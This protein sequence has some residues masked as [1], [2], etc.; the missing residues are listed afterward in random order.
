M[1]KVYRF[2]AYLDNYTTINAYIKN[3]YYNGKSNKFYLR[4][5][6]GATFEC[7]VKQSE[8]SGEYYKYQIIIDE[9]WV[10]IGDEMDLVEEHGLTCPLQ[11]GLVVR[12]KRFNDE[13]Y[14]DRN[15]F[16]AHVNNNQTSFVLWAPTA[17][18][19]YLKVIEQEKITI[20]PMQKEDKGAWTY[21]IEKNC[22][23]MIYKYIVNVNGRTNEALD[24]YGYGSIENAKASAVI[25]FNQIIT[26]FN[27]D[28]LAPM[29]SYCD[30]II[31][32]LSVRDFSSHP[33]TNI[34]HK[35]QFLG[36]I[37]EGKTD[38]K[39]NPV[40]YDYLK[41]FGYTHIQLMPVFDFATT[42]ELNP[43]M[44]YN[45]G[46]D[47]VQYNALEGSYSKNPKDPLSRINEFIQMIGFYHSKGIRVNMDVVYNHMYDMDDSAFERIVP[48]YYFRQ[49]DQG[50]I[51]NGSFCGNDVDSTNGMVRKFIIDSCVHFV[52]HYHI[53]GLRFDLM[54]ILD[55]ESMNE[56]V[57]K[58]Q[59][60]RADCMIYGEGWNM[61]TMLNEENRAS[62]LNMGEMP[63]VAHFNDFYRN[64]IKGPS[65]ESENH[66]SGYALGDTS[67][68][69]SAK[70]CL[71]GNILDECVVRLFNSP[72]QSLNYVECHD[73]ATLWDKIEKSNPYNTLEQKVNKQKLCNGLIALSFGI[74]FYHIGQEM[75]RTKLGIDN[76]Y[77]SPDE[78]NRVDYNQAKVF[79]EVVRYTKDLIDLRKQLQI[80][81]TDSRDFIQQ[82][83]SFE[84]LKNQAMVMHVDN[85]P[86]YGRISIYVNPS[87]EVIH[88]N[89][90]GTMLANELGK[91]NP[92]KVD[93]ISIKPHSM[94]VI[95]SVI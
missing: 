77:C 19:V 57:E 17:S 46:Y 61:P 65:N 24:P 95:S 78:I 75:C 11:Y 80:F 18:S 29:N 73:N 72:T 25:D 53:D 86:T 91:I 81:N 71:V 9:D 48:Y 32:E 22:H 51:S 64:H 84:T 38:I 5:K 35:G 16:G 83:V 14:N 31:C 93:E 30:A 60:L 63:K 45:W 67:Y 4:S 62:M 6:E 85:H 36:M 49:N 2:E 20:Y 8:K 52:E 3:T 66:I 56:I 69:E 87:Y 94:V 15:D 82:N 12:T 23:G 68:V 13:F 70:A 39:G 10:N 59:S 92:V 50:E 76:S 33:E 34:E 27:D 58:T 21:T 40:G 74:P 37:E 26:N 89:V 1:R 47:P 41:Q 55:I 79:S 54:G 90:H 43:S 28:K 42:D 88:K 44:L 7:K